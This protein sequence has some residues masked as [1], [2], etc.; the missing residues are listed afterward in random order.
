LLIFFVVIMSTDN[1]IAEIIPEV[2]EM[3][4]NKKKLRSVIS[5]NGEADEYTG[6]KAQ[7]EANLML[8]DEDLFPKS[9]STRM[10]AW[11]S[12]SS[13]SQKRP[14]RAQK[15]WRK[16]LSPVAHEGRWRGS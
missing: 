13:R 16:D 15:R 2:A 9:S 5:W 14:H 4:H 1:D 6:W 3:T 7:I 11:C 8:E 10:M 12:S